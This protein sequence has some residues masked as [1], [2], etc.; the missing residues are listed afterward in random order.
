MANNY[1]NYKA[2]GHMAE[3]RRESY[4]VFTRFKLFWR[5]V[6]DFYPFIITNLPLRSLF[7]FLPYDQKYKLKK[8]PP[9]ANPNMIEAI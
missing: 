3:G 5:E 2:S 8:S 6:Q 9:N 1:Y 4:F 7:K